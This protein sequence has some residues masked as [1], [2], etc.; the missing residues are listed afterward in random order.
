LT[1]VETRAV[2]GGA[3]THAGVHAAAASDPAGGLPGVREFPATA[4]GYARLPGWPGGFGTAALAGIEGTGSYG[5][6]LA[7]H[8]TAVGVRVAEAARSGRQDRRRQGKSD[9][10]MPSARPGPPSRAGPA[11]RPGAGT[12]RPRRSAR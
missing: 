4:G 3:D 9:P 1:I 7:R 5:V 10:A 11:A 8:I 12:A 2:T 6:G